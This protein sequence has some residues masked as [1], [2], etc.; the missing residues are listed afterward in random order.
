MI[1][2]GQYITNL[3]HLTGCKSEEV[4]QEKIEEVINFPHDIDALFIWDNTLEGQDFWADYY[5]DASPEGR[6][7]LQEILDYLSPPP[8]PIE[9]Y[10]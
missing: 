3:L 2:D 6:E 9:S 4:L 10:L 7:R 5:H 8:Q 1:V